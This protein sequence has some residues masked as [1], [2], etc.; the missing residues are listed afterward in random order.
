LFKGKA[1]GGRDDLLFAT[2]DHVR[3]L[4]D[5]KESDQMVV[6]YLVDSDPDV[7][8]EYALVRRE[9]VRIDDEPDRGGTKAAILQHVTGFAIT[10]WDWQKQEWTREWSTAVGNRTLLPTRVKLKLTLRM[11]DGNERSFETQAR[12]AIIRPLDF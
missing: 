4:R 10:Y 3:G 1:G 11:P 8:G 5:A 9:K 7:P 6:E 2:M 12:I